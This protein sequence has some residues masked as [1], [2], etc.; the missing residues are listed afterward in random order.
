MHDINLIKVYL[1]DRLY[2]RVVQV[3]LFKLP[4]LVGIMVTKLGGRLV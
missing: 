4:L 2:Y 3:A 1:K